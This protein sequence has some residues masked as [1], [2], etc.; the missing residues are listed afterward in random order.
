VAISEVV[1]E[2]K[3]WIAQK[4]KSERREMASRFTPSHDPTEAETASE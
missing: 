4:T 3:S 1:V 2:H